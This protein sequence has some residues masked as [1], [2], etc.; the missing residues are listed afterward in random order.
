MIFVTL[1]T[2]DKSFE[3]LLD[4]ALSL[5]TDEKVIIQYGSTDA[6]KKETKNNFELYQYVSSDEFE[7]YMKEARVIITHA[8]VGTIITGL[9]LH[10]K[11]IVAARRKQYKE[12]VNDHQLQ[13]LDTF[14]KDGYIIK[15]EDFSKLGELINIEFTPKDFK[16]NNKKFNECLEKEITKLSSKVKKS[17]SRK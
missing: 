12:H 16:E 8:G 4:A 11:M 6:S 15:L 1:G 14:S 7:N 13:I 5:E 10:K 3:R 9:K 17:K 2:Q